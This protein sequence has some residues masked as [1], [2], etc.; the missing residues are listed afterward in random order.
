MSNQ[1]YCKKCHKLVACVIES[2]DG[3]KIIQNGNV[4]INMPKGSSGNTITVRCVDGHSV[5]VTI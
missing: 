3:K 2:D 5:P 1:V 4:V